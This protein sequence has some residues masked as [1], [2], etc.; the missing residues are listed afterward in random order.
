MI[1][2]SWLTELW[3]LVSPETSGQTGRL[4]AL[5]QAP[6]RQSAS[7]GSSQNPATE[8]FQLIGR[9]PLGLSRVIST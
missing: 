5:A 1:L 4:C 9:G 7:A 2:R 3:K 6:E 8:A